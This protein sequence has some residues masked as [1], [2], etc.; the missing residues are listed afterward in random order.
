MNDANILRIIVCFRTWLRGA[1]S[2]YPIVN[3]VTVE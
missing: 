3:Q 2:P 1:K